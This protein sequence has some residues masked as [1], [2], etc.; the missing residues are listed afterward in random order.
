M[1]ESAKTG[2][3]APFE[4][5]IALRY[6]RARRTE[7]FVS[8]I[9]GFSLV[10]IA[11]GVATLI[12]VMSVM[13]GFRHELLKS[14]LGLNGHVTVMAADGYLTDYDAVAK[15]V[16]AVPG[17]VRAAPI[18]N[19]QVMASQNGINNGVAVRGMRVGDLRDLTAVSKTLSPGALA[20]FT[21]PDSI[22]IGAGL[23][24]SL[25]VVTGDEVTLIAPKGDVTPMGTTPR[26][27]TYRVAG[28]FKIGMTQYDTS[29][30]F[31]PLD[32]AQLFFDYGD[33]V[34][35]IETVVTD[36]DQDLSLLPAISKAAGS[37]RVIPWQD[38]NTSFFQALEVERNTMFLIL[39]LIIL[40]AALNIVSGLIM[41]VKDKSADIAIL[42]T[43]G[44][45][46]G[47]VMRVFFISGAS[48]GTV[49]DKRRCHQPAPSSSAASYSAG[50]MRDRPAMKTTRQ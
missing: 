8:V 3:F 24:A 9:S 50:S 19:G 6:L 30:V 4:W 14:I 16:R 26:I 36:P 10:G 18:V 13:N 44:A 23:A 39:S 17:V 29:F 34:S 5:M 38:T 37:P 27:K 22:I 43:M 31:M 48:I 45:T 42:R 12:I 21:K 40:V 46:R 47:A 2:I 35:S 1:A 32:E 25:H 41:L 28:T 15:R 7:S 11:L 33:S 20:N 49:I